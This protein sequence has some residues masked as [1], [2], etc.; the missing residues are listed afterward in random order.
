MKKI[1]ILLGLTMWIGVAHAS[2]MT[3]DVTRLVPIMQSILDAGGEES[4]YIKTRL[5]AEKKRIQE[6][7]AQDATVLL[8]EESKKLEDATITPID[9]QNALI[10]ALENAISS[11]TSDTDVLS[12]EEKR[13]YAEDVIPSEDTSF[14]KQT[15]SHAELLGKKIML[16]EYSSVYRE[17][18]TQ[19][20]VRLKSLRRSERFGQFAALIQL[21]KYFLI[22]IATVG[23]ERILRRKLISKI[24]NTRRRYFLMKL[25]AAVIYTA[26]TL[27][28][29][30]LLISDHPGFLASLAIIGAGVA[31][32]LQ[33]LIKD[34]VGWI[35]ILQRRYYRLG[36]RVSIGPITGDVID[37]SPLRTTL[38]EVGETGPMHSK[39][40]GKTVAIPNSRMLQEAV[41]NYH[42]TSDFVASDLSI[43]ITFESNWKKVQELLKALLLKHTGEF[44][45]QAQAQQRRRSS[46]FYTTW[47]ISEPQVHVDVVSSGIQLSLRFH[48]PIGGNRTIITALSQDILDMVKQEPDIDLAY[49]T[50]RVIRN[51]S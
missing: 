39:R 19:E 18:K 23:L 7:A 29:F 41:T 36:Q 24:T 2:A 16:E 51:L 5:E 21:G 11:M 3:Y 22:I 42:S 13:F 34:F 37:I 45:T 50:T 27:F 6:S 43:V 46:G 30:N 12:A 1:G 20:E 25:C 9:R 14:V 31:I 15:T 17:R 10:R 40:T 35:L 33:D 26:G 4:E 47:D 48:V 44:S 8:E 28:L 32:A 49:S 38:L